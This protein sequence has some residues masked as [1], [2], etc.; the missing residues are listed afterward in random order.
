MDYSEPKMWVTDFYNLNLGYLATKNCTSA[1]YDRYI[2]GFIKTIANKISSSM[3]KLFYF[4]IY[5]YFDEW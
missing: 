5:T 4:L 1:L 2:D 3:I